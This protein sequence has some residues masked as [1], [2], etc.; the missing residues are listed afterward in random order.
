[1]KKSYVGQRIGKFIVLDRKVELYKGKNG[2]LQSNTMLLCKCTKCG[3]E[4]WYRLSNAKKAKCCENLL[5][6]G[7]KK[8]ELK[9]NTIINNIT[10]IERTDRVNSSGECL[11]K[12]KCSCGNI[13]Y[14][15]ITRVR[16]G[17]IKSCGCSRKSIERTEISRK[18]IRE[19]RSK[20]KDIYVEGTSLL[21]LTNKLSNKNTSGHKGV[22]LN[23]KR[24]KWVA[25][26]KF[27]QKHYYLGSFYTIEEAIKARQRAEEKYFEPILKKYKKEYDMAKLKK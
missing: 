25:Q 23:K 8:L 12:C 14:T 13:F 7:K 16:N 20:I 18:A 24:N 19:A 6:M 26:I 15:S 1:M 27:R 22:Y 17:T 3:K 21:N 5:P 4:K 10:F 2:K 11:W 9:K